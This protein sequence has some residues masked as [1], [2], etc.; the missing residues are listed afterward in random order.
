MDAM[1]ILQLDY[2]T[3][4]RRWEE[5]RAREASGLLEEEE[6]GED[7]NVTSDDAA[8][9]RVVPL[10]GAGNDNNVIA[11]QICRRPGEEVEQQSDKEIECILEAEARELAELVAMHEAVGGAPTSPTDG[12][13]YDSD[14]FDTDQVFL[15][16]LD[17]NIAE[18]GI[19]AVDGDKMDMSAG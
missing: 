15:E 2:V 3:E 17:S 4:R 9:D 19:D 12:F 10:E 11:S 8:C 6:D 14:D 16:M 5:A 1:Q 7:G 18:A 13:G